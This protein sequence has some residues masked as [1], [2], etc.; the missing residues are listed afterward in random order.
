M[1]LSLKSSLIWKVPL[2]F[3]LV[4]GCMKPE[5]SKQSKTKIDVL[6]SRAS[7]SKESL[8]STIHAEEDIVEDPK[9]LS[10]SRIGATSTNLALLATVSAESTYPGYSISK[11][12]DGS[13]N[14]TVGPS[15]SW[16][17]NHPS[18]GKLPESV[19][20]KF[21]SLKTV[22]Q[23]DIYTS[24]GYA[25][26]NYTVQFRT[27]TTA[28][29]ITL[30]S[31]TGNTS[32]FRGHTFSDVSLLEIQI[33]CQLGPANQ[34]IYGRLNEVEIYG[35]AE[36]TLPT[37]TTNN[38]MLV[39]NS[40]ADA[41]QTISYLEY[42]YR[43][44]MNAF[45]SQYPGK[46][47]DEL[48]DIEDATG[49]NDQQPY[50]NFENQFGISSLR[51]MIETAEN[52]WL[53]NTA[54]DSTA[55]PDPDDSYMIETEIRSMANVNGN[56]KVGTS[57]YQFNSDGSYYIVG[58]PQQFAA[59]ALSGCK[60]VSRK[61]RFKYSTN[62]DYRM[63][64]IIDADYVWLGI[65]GS[66]AKAVTKSYKKK[67]GHWKKRSYTIG[68]EVYGDVFLAIDC[69]TSAQIESGYEEEKDKKVT[70]KVYY[71]LESRVKNGSVIADHYHEKIGTYTMQL[72]W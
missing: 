67:N 49:F 32:V 10:N 44:Y 48:A 23:I 35:P 62:G 59:A 6:D 58:V 4:L 37:I 53:A 41:N 43:Q 5:L 63:K 20:L 27:T 34:S 60:N 56:V 17:N 12:K 31:I 30:F 72:T 26:R 57:V 24:S 66:R 55:G 71:S 69:S 11:I 18:G 15:Y 64:C 13:R 1:K 22:N 54:G 3:T 29:W 33:I 2:L 36:P 9:Q 39:F 46:T 70:A 19:F 7:L 42:K 47:S 50:I 45:V 14:N 40:A 21:N 51:A 28:A 65:G 8:D 16:A 68:A 61:S 38:G 25:L 52:N